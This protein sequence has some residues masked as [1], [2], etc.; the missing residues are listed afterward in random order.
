VLDLQEAWWDN[1]LTQAVE[2]GGLSGHT[3]KNEILV[4]AE[5]HAIDSAMEATSATPIL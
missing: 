4:F 3:C 2:Y 1:C 5:F